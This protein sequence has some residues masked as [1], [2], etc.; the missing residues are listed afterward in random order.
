MRLL[1]LG[2]AQT[3]VLG[4]DELEQAQGTALNLLFG[5]VEVR[6]E[7]VD[8]LFQLDL[9]ERC[10]LC[11]FVL[12]QGG[13]CAGFEH[14]LQH[15]LGE[16][17]RCAGFSGEDSH[18]LCKA[19]PVFCVG[20]LQIGV[21]GVERSRVEGAKIA[22]QAAQQGVQNLVA[23]I[24]VFTHQAAQFGAFA[25]VVAVPLEKHPFSAEDRPEFLV[26]QGHIAG[27]EGFE[28][29]VIAGASLLHAG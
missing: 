18:E 27:E 4:G 28:L 9:F 3:S 8:E 10:Q 1:A 29:G 15:G 7:C 11:V 16:T 14:V 26:E 22:G 25:H 20:G 24:K 13:G 6:A 2:F 23:N 5:A 17:N 21:D 19:C 12:L